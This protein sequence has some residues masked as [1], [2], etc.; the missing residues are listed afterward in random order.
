[1]DSEKNTSGGKVWAFITALAVIVGLIADSFGILDA[2]WERLNERKGTDDT[3]P[4]TSETSPGNIDWTSPKD[5]ASSTSPNV[6]TENHYEYRKKEYTESEQSTLS[7]WKQYDQKTYTNYGEYGPWQYTPIEE[8]DSINVITETHYKWRT[9]DK[10]TTVGEWSEWTT[11]RRQNIDSN[12]EERVEEYTLYQYFYYE[13]PNCGFHMHGS[14]MPCLTDAG[15]CGYFIP[16]NSGFHEIR[17]E[18]PWDEANWQDWYGTGY[19]FTIINGERVF[20][21]K[22]ADIMSVG[23]RYSYR[24]TF[25]TDVA[26]SDWHYAESQSEFWDIGN[27]TCV[28]F[29]DVTA[30]ASCPVTLTTTYYYWRWSDWKECSKSDYYDYWDDEDKEVRI[31]SE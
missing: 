21:W 19:N 27:T 10:E 31:K 9:V 15:G 6:Q 13:C 16:E 29:M 1:M 14:D 22:S 24:E 5:T 20:K 3:T 26:T 4:S 8:S 18:L 2:I 11:E 7:G 17:D 28:E 30:Y 23:K 12:V 25:T